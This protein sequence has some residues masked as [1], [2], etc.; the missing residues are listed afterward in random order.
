MIVNTTSEIGVVH[1]LLGNIFSDVGIAT[2]HQFS[3]WMLLL[4][5]EF[6]DSVPCK[7]NETVLSFEPKFVGYILQWDL[8]QVLTLKMIE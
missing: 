5:T 1:H 2:V 4:V 6:I 3:F 7:R 8:V